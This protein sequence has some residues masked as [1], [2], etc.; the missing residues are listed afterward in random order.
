MI[1]AFPLAM[2]VQVTMQPI[3]CIATV[4]KDNTILEIDIRDLSQMQ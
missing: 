1:D 4:T 3:A 2:Y